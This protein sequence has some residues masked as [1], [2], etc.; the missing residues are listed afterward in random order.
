MKAAAA[1]LGLALG[2][3]GG[4]NRSAPSVTP[5]NTAPTTP[6]PTSPLTPGPDRDADHVDDACDRCPDEAETFQGCDDLDGCPDTSAACHRYRSNDTAGAPAATPLDARC[7][8][9]HL[10]P[11]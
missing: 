7:V 10:P 4:N 6:V 11:S 9:G 1:A 3:C 2:A 5:T 8:D